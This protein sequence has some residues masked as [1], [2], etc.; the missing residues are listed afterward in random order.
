VGTGTGRL[1]SLVSP[2]AAELA[3]PA[4]RPHHP[5]R[6]APPTH[7]TPLSP[8][9]RAQTVYQIMTDRFAR[10]S[11]D[12]SRCTNF[13]KYCG[14]DFQGIINNLDYIKDMGFTAIWI[15]P[16]QTQTRG[17]TWWVVARGPGAGPAAWGRARSV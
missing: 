9:T 4:C 8:P 11:G 15:S 16:V 10:G 14:G 7:P 6:A 1:A 5:R 12:M 13:N 2:W 17:L 3:P